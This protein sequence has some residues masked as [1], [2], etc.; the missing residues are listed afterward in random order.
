MMRQSYKDS[1]V[2]L[3]FD[4]VLFDTRLEVFALCAEVAR[5]YEGYRDNVESE[6]FF[7]FRRYLKDAWQFNLLYS[8]ETKRQD[9]S[10]I[11]TAA[12][13]EA[14]FLFASRFFAVRA[15]MQ[16][17]KSK[18]KFIRPHKF[19][20]KIIDR[21][22]ASPESF[23][24]LSTRNEESIIGI[25]TDYGISDVRVYGQSMIRAHGSKLQVVTET[26][27]LTS[28]SDVV[29]I[30]DMQSHLQTFAS[31]HVRCYQADW[32]YDQPGPLAINYE[33]ALNLIGDIVSPELTSLA[34]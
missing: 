10:F 15:E 20:Y 14:D 3:D 30:D 7:Q 27:I 5:R 2:L 18:Q 17:D 34:Y 24:I 31:T 22:V 25:F 6:E 26:G 11:Q 19:F 13:T 1:I 29:Y 21:L 28:F 23:R 8:S 33:R 12:P 4:G 32:G 16:D 9:Y